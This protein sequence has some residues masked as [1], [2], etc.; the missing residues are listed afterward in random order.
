M[1]KG[2][3]TANKRL[4]LE[5]LTWHFERVLV[6]VNDDA[7][8]RLGNTGDSV[9][10]PPGKNPASVAVLVRLPNNRYD[11]GMFWRVLFTL[12]A[13]HRGR[14][15]EEAG[16]T[17]VAPIERVGLMNDSCTI[18]RDLR[19]LF[20]WA[21]ET[22]MDRRRKRSDQEQEQEQE[23]RT[24]S[25]SP[26]ASQQQQQQQQQLPPLFWGISLSYSP[27]R[28]LQSFFLVFDGTRAVE[29]LFRFAMERDVFRVPD[30][31]AKMHIIQGFELGLSDFMEASGLPGD[32]PYSTHTVFRQWWT[33]QQ[34]QQQPED[35][36]AATITT[37][38]TADE[39]KEKK[40]QGALLEKELGSFLRNNCSHQNWDHMLDAGCPLVK[41]KRKVLGSKVHSEQ[42][43]RE[44]A[45]EK[46][47]K[48]LNNFN[49]S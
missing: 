5:Q 16:A 46:Y 31:T 9:D 30:R 2:T 38:T 27:R 15:G 32:S 21:E 11:F 47:K 44:A 48:T 43:I 45:T 29:S 24:P 4:Y 23:Q 40:E 28:H 10:T 34:Q 36:Q 8:V 39:E 18:L 35:G 25:A 19:D 1:G 14:D 7:D 6:L 41:N 17:E 26:Q 33:R 42:L 12:A 49:S 3:L 22:R 13:E 20:A 37:T